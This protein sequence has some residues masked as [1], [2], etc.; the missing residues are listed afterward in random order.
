MEL[1]NTGLT[2]WYATPDAP[3]PPQTIA[4]DAEKCL[5]V[6]VRPVHP[7]NRVDVMFRENTGPERFIRATLSR[8]DYGMNQQFFRA[9]FP[10]ISPGTRVEYA[11][12]IRQ[13]GRSIDFRKGGHYPSYFLITKSNEAAG[14]PAASTEPLLPHPYRLEHLTRGDLIVKV[15]ELVG[16]TPEGIRLITTISG[17]TY[18]GRINGNASQ[19][20]G[21]WLTIRPDG[22]GILDARVTLITD[23]GATILIIGSGTLDLGRD[24]YRNVLS[25]RYPARA[26]IVEFMRFLSSDPNYAWLVRL[27][28]VG[29]GYAS[30]ERVCYDIYGVHSLCT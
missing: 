16:E 27:Q 26:P 17:G 20:S 7:S 13:A 3:A 21:D 28:C 1:T 25:S 11:P 8:T 5:T 12:V 10:P 22:I 19:S 6:G 30:T 18:R 2:G 23:D 9:D 4:E 15:S 24:G 29:I 14:G